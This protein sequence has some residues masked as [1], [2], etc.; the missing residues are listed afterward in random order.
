MLAYHGLDGP[1]I[2][3]T[4]H[5]AA[6]VPAYLFSDLPRHTSCTGSTTPSR[7][8]PTPQS[9][10]KRC[11][12]DDRVIATRRARR[13]ADVA[14]AIDVGGA[15]GRSVGPPA[16]AAPRRDARPRRAICCAR[17]KR[18]SARSS[19]LETGKPWKNA[20][21]EVGSSADLAIFMDGE[22]SRFYG[23]TMTSPIP[24]R[25]VQ[26]LRSRS[27]SARRSCRS[28]ARSPASRGK[29]FP[30]LLCGNAV[31]VKSHELTP[32]TGVAFGKLLKDA[33]L[34]RGCLR[35]VQGFGPEVGTPLVQDHS[36]RRRQLHGIVGDRQADSED[37]QR[38]AACSPR[39]ASSWAAR[40]HSSSATMRICELAAEHAVASAF[41]DAGQRCASGSRILVFDA[42]LRRVSRGVSRA[43]ATGEGR[44]RSA[45]TTA[46][47]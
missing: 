43:R 45:M 39:S 41:I 17:A 6:S 10:E 44:V 38:A 31:V 14:H 26:T 16:G 15:R 4:V 28:T 37:G 8:P 27:A 22:G 42:R 40:I 19:R 13:A 30:A 47:R 32:Y 29:C 9:F 34:P 24:N 33:G 20:V 3:R 5:R 7:R 12:I 36:R 25:S 21:A 35:R 23:K 11:P 46:A 18:S 2:A 1:S